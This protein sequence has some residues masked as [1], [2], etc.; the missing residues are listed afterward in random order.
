MDSNLGDGTAQTIAVKRSQINIV[1]NANNTQFILSAE[2]RIGIGKANPQ[3]RLHIATEAGEGNS[4]IILESPDDQSVLSLRADQGG[5]ATGA[6]KDPSINFNSGTEDGEHARLRY[7]ADYD[8]L[9]LVMRDNP[10]VNDKVTISNS[11]NLSTGGSRGVRVGVRQ[12]RGPSGLSAKKLP[13]GQVFDSANVAITGTSDFA[14]VTHTISGTPTNDPYQFMAVGDLV[15]LSMAA[16]ADSEYVEITGL[17]PAYFQTA[18][19]IGISGQALNI[20]LKPA[21]FR[22]E[23]DTTTETHFLVG[24]GR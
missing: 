1:D 11:D 5:T 3:R 22:L 20:W 14:L 10:V 4:T 16:P 15:A 8:Q 7:Y 12:D 18:K 19:P 2:N 17:S 23:D 9:G 6:N 24:G 13:D 21:H